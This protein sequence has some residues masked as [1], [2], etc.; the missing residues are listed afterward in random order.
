MT[1]LETDIQFLKS[2]VMADVPEGGG[3]PTGQA[4]EHGVSNAIHPDVSD[5]DRAGGAV[6]IMKANLAVL[7]P[8]AEAYSGANI[9][10]ARAPTDPNVSITLAECDLFA[11]RAEI[12]TAIANYLIRG[13]RWNGYLLENHVA[14]MRN[15]LIFQRV[16]AP[17]PPVNGTLCLVANEGLPSE[18]LQYVRVTRATSEVRT[19]TYSAGGGF[20]DF[21]AQVVTAELGAPLDY[22]FAGSPPDRSFTPTAGKTE[23][24]DTTV[25]DAATYYG[26]S[27]LTAVATLGDTEV[28]VA[29]IYSQLVPSSRTEVASLDQRPAAARTLV[30]AETP[31]RVEVAVAAHTMRIQVRAQNQGFA[32]V[33]TLKPLP[34][35]GTI[36]VS[37]LIMGAWYTLQDD[38][39][40]KLEGAGTGQ[41][42]YGTGSLAITLQEMADVGG[43]I[44]I[45]WA[46]RS[47]FTNRSSQGAAVRAPEYC[48][49]LE[50]G[51]YE[52]GSAVITWPSAGVIRT[53][54]AGANGKITGDAA[55]EIDAPT[56]TIY[57]RPTHM[58]DPGAEF[59]ID[60]TTSTEQLEVLPA[61]SVDSA[62]MA[63][64][65]LAQQPAAGSLSI[66]WAT[67]REVSNTSGGTLEAESS[68][69]EAQKS[70]SVRVGIMASEADYK[71]YVVGE[72]SP[73]FPQGSSWYYDPSKWHYKGDKPL[74]GVV[75]HTNHRTSTS[76][77]V[78]TTQ[79][80]QVSNTRVVDLHTISDDGN[81]G[82]VGGMG[83]V[84]YAAKT[85]SLK[86][87]DLSTSTT[88]YKADHE[89]SSVFDPYG[90]DD[91]GAASNTMKGGGYGTT[92]VGAQMLAGSS[93]VAR[94]KV[95]TAATTARTMSFAPPEVV[96]DLCRY[97]TER[98]VPGS[99]R[100]LWMGE[101]YED[102]D[103]VLYRGRSANSLGVEAGVMDYAAG[104]ARMNNWVV[105]G[106]P[107]AFTLQS[108]WTQRGAWRTASVFFRTMS[109]PVKP[110]GLNITVLDQAG[111]ALTATADV[112]GTITGPHCIGTFDY[113]TGLGAIQ[114]GDFVLDSSL[115]A[116]QKAEWWYSAD[117]VGAVQ[118][119]K[120]WR[121]WP[122]D[123]A[124]L[125][126]NAVAYY[127][128][129]LDADILGL[130]PERLPADGRVPIY[131][132]G[133]YA[134]IGH[135]GTIAAATYANGATIQ[136]GRE[137]LSRVW[138]EGA[139]GKLIHAGYTPNL[140]AGTIA[141]NNTT[142]WVQPVKVMHRIE[143][144]VRIADLTIGGRLKLNKALT[145]N[146]PIG[147][148]VASAIMCGT[149]QA[150]VRAVFDRA[151]WDGAWSD[152]PQP[153]AQ[154]TAQYN[155]TVYPIVVTNAG[156]LTERFVLR[157]LNTTDFECIGEHVGNIGT[158]SKNVDFAPINPIKG[159]PYFTLKAAG[160]GAGWGPGSCLFVFTVGAIASFASVRSVQPSEPTALDYQFE[161]LGRGSID[162]A[163]T[164]P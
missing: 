96:I 65:T 118:P 86:M 106:S 88:S 83:T 134:V 55:G 93:V 4:I 25:A 144:T 113:Q 163:P 82:F 152:D 138:L 90:S 52:A 71:R 62:G 122:V 11:T 147:T 43:D 24:R 3:A 97:T 126:Y 75:L 40:G 31:R 146:Y 36:I 8:N 143:Q 141:V 87:V 59:S 34:E 42:I 44:V 26:T 49:T 39:A 161:L 132:R 85:V 119:G 114:Y 37:A 151:T 108:L 91:Y 133:G 61:P 20:V 105:N 129:P 76:K 6:S 74:Y 58:I 64:I 89:Y 35:P 68:S 14:G 12:A 27:P 140:D 112:N 95:G 69:K 137:R 160:W 136:C 67:A 66:M 100:F 41:V 47:A 2:K 30:L 155:D 53:A 124:T 72:N 102:V 70:V 63:T 116:A 162:R 127:Y 123:P 81:G 46:E 101:T 32:Y 15:I 54:V 13:P 57:L 38:G 77:S 107:V 128:L 103:G 115:T 150:R 28:T 98:V 16:G 21:Q 109:A 22:D 5:V 45:Q 99:V 159:A 7:S 84:A 60:Y 73:W 111:T 80:Q 104:L 131:R 157:F 33:A 135:T 156:A 1:I 110:T 142:G 164:A 121:P 48:F 94:Y 145:H 50:H 56:G 79:S 125:R 120:I 10:V 117:E 18:R 29:S 149:L 17:L 92:S 154:S 51:G 148:T 139:D 19:F 23:I 153:P 78:M 130:P 158:G 9:I